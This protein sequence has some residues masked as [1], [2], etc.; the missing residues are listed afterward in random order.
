MTALTLTQQSV[1]QRPD[2]LAVSYLT[3]ERTVGWLT[4]RQVWYLAGLIARCLSGSVLAVAID[5]GPYLA[6]AELA[7]WRRG[8]VLVPLDPHDPVAR[9]RHVAAEAGAS[10]IVTKDWGDAKKLADAAEAEVIDLSLAVPLF[11]LSEQELQEPHEQDPEPECDP[12][13]VAY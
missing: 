8:M 4:Y 1:K 12:E 3:L 9:L 2:H 10:C 5:D 6:L 7:G 11:E 13:S